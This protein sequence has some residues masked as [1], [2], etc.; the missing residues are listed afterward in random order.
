LKT[1]LSS[2]SSYFETSRSCVSNNHPLGDDPWSASSWWGIGTDGGAARPMLTMNQIRYQG[3]SYMTRRGSISYYS[4]SGNFLSRHGNTFTVDWRK[5]GE[6]GGRSFTDGVTYLFDSWRE[7]FEFGYMHHALNGTLS[8]TYFFHQQQKGIAY[9]RGFLAGGGIQTQMKVAAVNITANIN[10]SFNKAS[11]RSVLNP[12]PTGSSGGGMGFIDLEHAAL[13]EYVGLL[14]F[15]FGENFQG[16]D[17]PGRIDI[18]NN[19]D[20][21][22]AVHLIKG[23]RYHLNNGTDIN[24]HKLFDRLNR[25]DIYTNRDYG[26]N[27]GTH[28]VSQT[29]INLFGSSTKIYFEIPLH[30][31]GTGIDPFIYQTKYRNN[32]AN[33]NIYWGNLG[34]LLSVP[35]NRDKDLL[36]ALGL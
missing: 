16:F 4:G 23:L 28:Y 2:V 1:K 11:M 12:F 33:F 10:A 22:I 20:L 24:L 36:K 26:I 25:E 18:V 35:S 15:E 30:A 32:D 3:D 31:S 9:E 19:S 13:G 14:G 5:A 21:R 27:G 34:I 8:D 17:H 6:F 29:N 7:G